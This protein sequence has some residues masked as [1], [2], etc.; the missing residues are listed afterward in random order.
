MLCSRR[1]RAPRCICARC[2]NITSAF[3]DQLQRNLVVRHTHRNRVKSSRRSV[4]YSFVFL[5]NQGKRARPELINKRS[6]SC[7]NFF[8]NSIQC[9]F[10]CNMYN[11]WIIRRS[12]FCRICF[13]RRLLIKR[14]RPQAVNGLRWKCD[15]ASLLYDFSRCF[16]DRFIDLHSVNFFYSCFHKFYYNTLIL[17]SEPFTADI[18][19]YHRQSLWPGNFD[20]PPPSVSE[21]RFDYSEIRIQ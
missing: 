20:N 1:T 7:R 17:F 11:Q 21:L 5:Q 10:L 4:R 8:H 16:H 18:P 2:R 3:P 12:A 13:S 6:C 9:I 15:Q 19:R 14:I